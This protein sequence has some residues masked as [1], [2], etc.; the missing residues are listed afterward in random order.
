ML[1]RHVTT[2]EPRPSHDE[3]T[4]L[5]AD[6]PDALYFGT[7]SWNYPGWQGHIYHRRYPANG[8]PAR[9]LAEYAAWPLFRTVGIDS[10]HYRP[11]STATLARYSAALPLGF[12]CLAKV[13]NRITAATLDAPSFGA[14]GGTRNPDWLS[15]SRYLD[16]VLE[17]LRE[18][19]TNHLGPQIFELQAVP[20]QLNLSPGHF[21][22]R[23]DHFF[24]RLP[25]DVRYAVEIR[26]PD[27][28]TP[29]YFSVLRA[30]RV[31]HVFSSWTRMPSIGAQLH[32][33]ESLTADFVVMRA[34]NRPGRTFQ[35][36]V[37]A[38][39]PYDRVQD[40]NPALR[41]D[42]V[43][44]ARTALQLRIPAYLLVGNRA[45]G[46]SPT[47]IAAVAR[48][49]LAD[50]VTRPSRRETPVDGPA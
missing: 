6:L 9:M 24:S 26:N 13:W 2:T 37:D 27:Y 49:L 38:F 34:L 30:H 7:S 4:Q 20:T 5:A 3:A 45:E 47:T 21:A 19:F 32:E 42:I 41:Q 31:A 11:A 39:A 16:E 48:A 14:P 46:N 29:T 8:S 40:V 44:L 10:F 22:D 35:E 15:A 1:P 17:P 23:L 18:H 25:T 28:L 12:P 36:A 43:A 33:H 50:P